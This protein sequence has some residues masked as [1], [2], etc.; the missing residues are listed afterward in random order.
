VAI[1]LLPRASM[2][3]AAYPSATFIYGTKRQKTSS[4]F[5]SPYSN[6]YTSSCVQNM[7]V[8]FRRG[9][10]TGALNADGV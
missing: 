6:P 10:L 8:K 5:F 2:H 7:M 1:I 9:P 3:S 4:D